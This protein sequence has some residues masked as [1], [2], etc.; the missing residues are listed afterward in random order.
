MNMKKFL[1]S[2]TVFVFTIFSVNAQ[3][4][5]TSTDTITT[6]KIATDSI[7]KDTLSKF[8]K[9]NKKAEKL[10]KIIPVPI[11]SY[12][13]ETGSVFGLAKFNTVRLVKSDSIS[14]ESSFSE[15]ITFSTT[16]QFKVVVASNLYL[17]EN[18]FNIIGAV[19]YIE[20]PEYILGVGNVV[21]R[22]SVEQIKSNRLPFSNAFLVGINKANTF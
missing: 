15:L 14:T 19:A 22:D 3:E 11:V 2:L 6:D 18:K 8:A 4:T 12:S 13:T 1:I 7:P 5:S 9:F 16:G 17:K 21:S 10:F 20:F